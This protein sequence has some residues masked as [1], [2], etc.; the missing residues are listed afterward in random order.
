MAVVSARVSLA[1]FL[2]VLH[3]HF[4]DIAII[5]ELNDDDE[6]QSFYFVITC[7]VDQATTTDICQMYWDS[8][9]LLDSILHSNCI[10]R[11]VR[12]LHK[13]CTVV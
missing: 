6:W 3:I 7:I 12:K 10:D 4:V 8:E 5:N 11:I 1:V 13:V 9:F 2:C